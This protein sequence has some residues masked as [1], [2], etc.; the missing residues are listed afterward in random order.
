MSTTLIVLLRHIP[1]HTPLDPSIPDGRVTPSW[2]DASLRAIPMPRHYCSPVQVSREIADRK[3]PQ[4]SCAAH[5]N[6]RNTCLKGAFLIVEKVCPWLPLGC[7]AGHDQ[8]PGHRGHDLWHSARPASGWRAPHTTRPLSGGGGHGRCTCGPMR[9][10]RC[11]WDR[12]P[13]GPRDRPSAPAAA[14]RRRS[15]S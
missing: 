5:N 8:R 13:C 12:R 9:S 15:R 14:T 3:R 1:R 7:F 4:A 2:I 10:L 11:P 6:G